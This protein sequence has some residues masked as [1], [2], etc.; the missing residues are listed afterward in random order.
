MKKKKNM[1]SALIVFVSMVLIVVVVI[2]T[3]CIQEE[4]PKD[5]NGDGYFQ[6]YYVSA[7]TCREFLERHKE[8]FE[9][10]VKTIKSQPTED[11]YRITFDNDGKLIIDNKLKV[12]EN[13]IEVLKEIY[14]DDIFKLNPYLWI[15]ASLTEDGRCKIEVHLF[16]NSSAWGGVEYRDVPMENYHPAFE[17]KFDDNWFWFS[18]PA[19]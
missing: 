5:V 14:S 7:N 10:F 13:F 6:D 8:S 15:D 11:T 18:Y 3:N 2:V 12:N 4:Y 9:Y 1:I 17:K 16:T 19:I